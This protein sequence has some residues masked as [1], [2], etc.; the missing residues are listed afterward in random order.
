MNQKYRIQFLGNIAYY[1]YLFKFSSHLG[2]I[3][4]KRGQ[5]M[6][7]FASIHGDIPGISNSPIQDNGVFSLIFL[8]CMSAH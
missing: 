2:K 5:E 6:A 3:F 1:K 7:R 4:I 8:D